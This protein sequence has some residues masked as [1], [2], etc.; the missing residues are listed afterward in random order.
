VVEDLV[1]WRVVR[2]ERANENRAGGLAGRGLAA[3]R[4]GWVER[5]PDSE[6]GASSRAALAN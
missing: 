6:L 2:A 5:F 4:F 1:W 3:H